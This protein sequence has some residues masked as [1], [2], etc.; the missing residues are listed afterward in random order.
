MLEQNGTERFCSKEEK[1]K[2]QPKKRKDDKVD[3]HR[4]D[5]ICKCTQGTMNALAKGKQR[6][7]KLKPGYLLHSGP[8]LNHI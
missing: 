1:K 3:Q 4:H 6:D 5:T 8:D 7:A 2:Y